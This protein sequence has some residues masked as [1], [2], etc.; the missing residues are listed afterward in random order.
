MNSRVTHALRP[1]FIVVTGFIV[2]V[3]ATSYAARFIDDPLDRA[4]LLACNPDNYVPVLDEF[5]LFLTDYGIDLVAIIFP[6]W[7]VGY[8]VC[9]K[10]AERR[11]KVQRAFRGLAVMFGLIYGSGIWWMH[12]TYWTI[13]IPLGVAFFVGLWMAGAS[14]VRLSDAALDEG[15]RVFWLTLLT[16][17]LMNALAEHFLKDTVCRPR[18][19]N[20]ANADWNWAIRPIPNGVVRGNY[21][22]VSGH[23]SA[24]FAL[25]TP[26]FWALRNRWLQ[27]AIIVVCAL[28]GFTRIYVAAHY[29]YC[30]LMG[31][32][33]GFAIGTLVYFTFTRH[34]RRNAA[35]SAAKA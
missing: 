20:I 27:G 10:K 14:F 23:A 35:L 21:S 17:F 25:L 33:L 7:A 19:F 1:W 12:Y 24:L 2:L 26:L 31:S 6:I 11:P 9:R 4:I 16:V 18:P 3:A 29:P 8:Y 5:M 32:L 15:I 30:V 28:H 22:Y 34:R 13:C